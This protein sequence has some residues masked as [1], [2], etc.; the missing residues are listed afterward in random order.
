MKNKSFNFKMNKCF[1]SEDKTV[2]IIEGYASVYDV[3]DS[4]NEVIIKG[5]FTESI[6]TF[7][8]NNEYIPMLFNHQMNKVIGG[9]DPKLIKDTEQ[10]LYVKGEIDLNTQAGAETYSLLSKKYI[11]SFSVGGYVKND[12]LEWVKDGIIK[13]IKMSLVEISPTPNPAN[14]DAKV[15]NVKSAV[16]FKNYDLMDEN[17]EW[18]KSKAINQIKKHTDSDDE[19]SSS[20]KNGF[21][22][23]DSSKPK[24]LTSYKLPY[25]YVVDGEFKVVPKALAAIV[26]VLNGGRGGVDIPDSDKEKIKANVSKYY[27]K[28]GKEDPFKNNEKSVDY[29]LKT[30]YN[31]RIEAFSLK[32][33][34]L[35][36]NTMINKLK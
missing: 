16:S 29:S 15:T 33:A 9:F 25:T 21:M 8:K 31:H 30:N 22:W 14:K 36:L 28:M 1:V 19:A 26:S 20:Y 13:I 27:K 5:A 18:D 35:K 11:N 24:N 32:L 34:V 6:E 17:T 12:D 3:V 7:K 4:Y 23:F 2:G 10:G